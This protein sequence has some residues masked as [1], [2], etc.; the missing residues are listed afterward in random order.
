MNKLIAEF[1]GGFDLCGYRLDGKL[2][3]DSETGASQIPEWPD[4]IEFNNITFAREKVETFSGG[5]EIASY[6]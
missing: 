2:L 1:V 5:Y 3:S 4:T 6:C